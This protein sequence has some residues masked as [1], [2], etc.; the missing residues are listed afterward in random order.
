MWFILIEFLFSLFIER[1]GVEIQKHTHKRKKRG[2]YP[3]ILTKQTCSGIDILHGKSKHSIFLRDTA[4]NPGRAR[5]GMTAPSCRSVSQS[6]RSIWFILPARILVNETL[7]HL[8]LLS[9]LVPQ[10][11]VAV[12]NYCA[13]MGHCPSVRWRWIDIGHFFFLS[14][15]YAVEVH[16]LAKNREQGRCPS[17]LIEQAWSIKDLL[18][19]F[20][21]NFS[22]GT[23]RLVPSRQL[24]LARSSKQSQ[25]RI[26]F[27]LPSHGASHKKR[28][29]HLELF[30]RHGNKLPQTWPR[31]NKQL[32]SFS[33]SFSF[34]SSFILMYLSSR[35]KYVLDISN[36]D[37]MLFV[38][39]PS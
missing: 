34:F 24:H 35:V 17:I 28:F 22:C 4:G 23:R 21:G 32:F 25:R 38:I 6:Q 39:H 14:R 11:T 7:P 2:Q 37:K 26:W 36:L 1:V 31:E 27:I 3:A 9:R 10:V 20:R 8:L 18:H 5:V 13:R 16:K 15:V 19:G 33:T 30:K 12:P 29:L